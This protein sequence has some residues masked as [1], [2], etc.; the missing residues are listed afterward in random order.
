MDSLNAEASL[1]R[2]LETRS[3]GAMCLTDDGLRSLPGGLLLRGELADDGVPGVGVRVDA[4][5]RPARAYL[6][7]RRGVLTA[8]LAA[9]EEHLATRGQ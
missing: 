2:R 9:A 6:I 5:V 7:D 4:W 3:G 8:R 1:R